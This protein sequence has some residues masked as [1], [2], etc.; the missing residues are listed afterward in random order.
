MSISVA[1]AGPARGGVWSAYQEMCLA[2][3]KALPW[4]GKIL[5]ARSETGAFDDQAAFRFFLR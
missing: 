2:Y 1:H 3:A 5:P 4:P